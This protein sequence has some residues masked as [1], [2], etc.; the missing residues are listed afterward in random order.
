MFEKVK[1][2]QK[3]FNFVPL[4]QRVLLMPHPIYRVFTLIPPIFNEIK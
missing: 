1:D 4:K 3:G 2:N